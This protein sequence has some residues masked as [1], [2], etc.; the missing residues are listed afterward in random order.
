MKNA[1]A[2]SATLKGERGSKS[3]RIEFRANIEVRELFEM[4]ASLSGVSVSAF[5]KMAGRKLAEEVI[6]S[7]RRL[8]LTSAS[9]AKMIDLLRNPPEFNPYL[10]GA[11]E[12]SRHEVIDLG[13]PKKRSKQAEV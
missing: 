11:I 13:I 6:E 5:L 3:E 8:K 2:G 12:S 1:L 9:Y 4:A 7:D 10:K